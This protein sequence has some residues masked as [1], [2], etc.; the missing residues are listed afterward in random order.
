MV[1]YNKKGI[2]R[3][4]EKKGYKLEEK[5]KIKELKKAEALLEKIE[6]KDKKL[7]E[8]IRNK[9]Q[10]FFSERSILRE[11]KNLKR[12]HEIERKDKTLTKEDFT[13]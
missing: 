1:L 10:R 6:R 3:K 13:D 2:S 5:E 8:I 7:G 4:V 11:L 12:K 9:C